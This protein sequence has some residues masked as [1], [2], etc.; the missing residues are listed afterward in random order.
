MQNL[1]TRNL[2]EDRRFSQSVPVPKGR[3]FSVLR[4]N[5][6]GNPA[7]IS[8]LKIYTVSKVR[9]SSCPLVPFRTG[10]P[11]SLANL[12]LN[13]FLRSPSTV[14][15]SVGKHRMEPES[16]SPFVICPQRFGFIRHRMRMRSRIG[17]NQ[18]DKQQRSI[19]QGSPQVH[20]LARLFAPFEFGSFH[21][22]SLRGVPAGYL[23]AVAGD[24]RQADRRKHASLLEKGMQIRGHDDGRCAIENGGVILAKKGKS[25]HER[26]K[27]QPSVSQWNSQNGRSR[28]W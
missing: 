24:N 1:L 28:S 18:P 5:P 27:V 6:H 7:A 13:L 10:T 22:E 8:C 11:G 19:A 16:E 25:V 14:F 26:D 2:Q 3:D 21:E 15:D 17:T 23:Y 4:C 20:V 9:N 12:A